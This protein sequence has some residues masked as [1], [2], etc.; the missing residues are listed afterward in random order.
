MTGSE[1]LKFK[2][3]GV[4]LR[5]GDKKEENWP[6]DRDAKTEREFVRASTFAKGGPL[7]FGEY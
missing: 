3:I 6:K 7:A 2:T 5:M 4:K 1:G